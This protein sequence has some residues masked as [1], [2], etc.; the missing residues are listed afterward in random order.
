MLVCFLIDK[1]EGMAAGAWCG[2]G[3]VIK[4]SPK[5]VESYYG[6]GDARF[7][8][9][10]AFMSKL[11][12][13]GFLSGIASYFFPKEVSVQVRTETLPNGQVQV[14]PFF[15]INGEEIAPELLKP[16]RHQKVLGYHVVLDGHS[17]T[18]HKQ[19]QGKTTRLTKRKAAEFLTQLGQSGIAIRSKDGKVQPRIETVKPDVSLELLQDDS[20]RVQS[21]LNTPNGI[22]L[23]KPTSLDQLKEEDGWYA[24]G[25]D[26]L[27]VETSNT[28]LD[29]ILITEG[30]NE[31]LF[32]DDVPRFL[33]LL[34]EESKHIR[35][36]DKNEPLKDLSVFTSS[37]ENR[38]KVDGNAEAISISTSLVYSGTQGRQYEQ[39]ATEV[40]RYEEKGGGFKRVSE[41]WVDVSPEDIYGHREACS[42]LTDKLGS[43]HN[44]QGPDIPN[45]LSSLLEAARRD[46]KWTSPWSVY[47]SEAVKNAHRI[48]DTSANV[49]FHL[50]I[51]DSDGRSLLQLDPI[52]NHE[53]FRIS[54]TEVESAAEEGEEWVRRQNAWIK[55]D[56]IKYKKINE[57][58][59]RLNLQP[60]PNGFTF[61]AS[62]R[63]Q[64]IDLFSVLGTIEHSSAYADFLLKLADFEKIEDVPLPSNLRTEIKFRP[65]QK[66]GFNWLAFLH[67]F[68]LNGILADDMGLGKTLQTLAM[69]QRAREMTNSN[70]PSIIICPTSVVNN[71]KSE[72]QKFFRNC[73]VI[74]YNGSN[75]H[76]QLVHLKHLMASSFYGK[77]CPLLITS[78]DIARL[79]HEKLNQIAWMY[80]VVDEGHNIKNPDAQRTKA[81]KTINGQHKLALTGTPIQNNLEELW[82]LFD[83]AMPG[84][85]G[86]RTAFRDLYGRNGKINWD[87]VRTGKAPLKERVHPFIMRRL[88]ENVAKDLPP[89]IVID[90]KIELTPQQ[91]ALYKQVTES[92]EYRR[93]VEEVDQKGVGRSQPLILAAFTKLRAICN[94][95]V[96]AQ[97]DHRPADIRYEHSGKLDSLKELMEEIVEGEHRTL[98]FSQSTQMLDI[99]EVFFTKW[100]ITFVRLDGS[101]PPNKR[102]ELVDEF[103]RNSNL[104]CFL[105]STKAGGTG[106]NL[107]GADTVVFYD[108]DWNPA[109]DSQAQDRAYRIGQTKPVTVYKLI[110]KGTIEEKI[111]ERQGIKKSMADEIIGADVEGFKDLTKQE[112]L[113][114]FKLDED[115]D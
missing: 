10:S 64:V 105:I 23:D 3:F 4:R 107:T 78:Y 9:G 24:V 113:A 69:I 13:A 74:V 34:Q 93:M 73:Q 100:K 95:P 68:G 112:L 5:N 20:L 53:R 98:L 85:L 80:V 33:K 70:L 1:T 48:I 35:S 18:V 115:A 60:G 103:N 50:N 57:G 41:G 65:Y 14:T 108:H 83:Y 61:P 72:V 39:T 111:L 86:N 17:L 87:A 6:S 15:T 49:V 77:T 104:H 38:V 32:G 54:H 82:S 22:V 89:K 76:K 58:V 59:K 40:D 2:D 8:K 52:Y 102:T 47:F 94:H 51:V 44:I 79:D 21:E 55:V 114:L 84:F 16:D 36:V 11:Q 109:N 25:E 37:P 62:Q 19:T 90:Q 96:L 88:K 29:R 91:V 42:E 31:V 45:A 110:S 26:L 30:G 92:P 66:H 75:R 28:S 43:L 67:R 27:R 12:P 99:I 7:E 71:W 97:G 56:Q 101:T 106:L 63:E 81:I 46:S